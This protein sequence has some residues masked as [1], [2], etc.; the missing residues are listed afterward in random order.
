MTEATDY[1]SRVPKY[2]FPSTLAEQ[3]AALAGHPMIRRLAAARVA[4]SGDRHRPL[5]HYVNPQAS[6]NDTNGL[7]PWQA[8]GDSIGVSLQRTQGA[9]CELVSLDAWE[10]ASIYP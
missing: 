4:L 2:D 9:P 5:Y 7:G 3:E 8:A 10:M 1:T 6:L